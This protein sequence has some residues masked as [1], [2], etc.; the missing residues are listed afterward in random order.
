MDAQERVLASLTPV[1][2]DIILLATGVEYA[3]LVVFGQEV[4]QHVNQVSQ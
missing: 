3:I 4:S 2:M 1:T